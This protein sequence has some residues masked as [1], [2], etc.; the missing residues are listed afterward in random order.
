M[1]DSLAQVPVIETVT[2]P[3]AATV[4]GLTEALAVQAPGPYA[5]TADA[6]EPRIGAT[7]A[8]AV[9]ASVPK[10][11]PRIFIPVLHSLF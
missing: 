3:P 1:K 10:I 4:E 7:T 11:L 9:R 2:D 8:A 5:G 6:A